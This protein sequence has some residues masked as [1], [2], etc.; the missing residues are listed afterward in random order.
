MARKSL[1]SLV[2]SS[3][4]LKYSKS[5]IIVRRHRSLV[6]TTSKH[7]SM[8]AQFKEILRVVLSLKFYEKLVL[9]VASFNEKNCKDWAY[10]SILPGWVVRHKGKIITALQSYIAFT[11]HEQVCIIQPLSLPLRTRILCKWSCPLLQP[12]THRRTQLP[13]SIHCI[14]HK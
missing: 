7:K 14:H 13:L 6:F 10:S 12:H 11:K 4:W 9:V 2:A 3:D 1:A 8:I 5:Y